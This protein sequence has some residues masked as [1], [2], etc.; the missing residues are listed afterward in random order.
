MC[1]TVILVRHGEVENP[2]RI[3]Y[4]RL[5]GFRLSPRGEAQA[6]A[7]GQALAR[8]P[9][10]APARTWDAFYSS[11]QER[12]RQTAAL[13]A[14][15]LDLP[16]ARDEELLDEVRTPWD[17]HPMDEVDAREWDFYTGSP[18]GFEQPLD[19]VDRLWAFLDGVSTR[20]PGGRVLAVTHGD[21]LA[22][23]LLRVA[24]VP[25]APTH[26]MHL[27]RLGWPEDYPPPASA[28]ELLLR[29]EGPRVRRVA[30]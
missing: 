16:P 12:T 18:D 4:G 1:T 6:R 30:G 7:T 22:F 14:R 28:W 15:E 26:R 21:V 3:C 8:L 23:G 17:G 20:H 13:L 2:G 29:P 25:L 27:T 5:P 9:G 11:P 10:H 24:G 19:I